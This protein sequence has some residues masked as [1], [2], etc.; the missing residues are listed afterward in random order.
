MTDQRDPHDVDPATAIQREPGTS[1]E[2]EV[3]A[4]VLCR[5]AE[6]V[7]EVL[8]GAKAED[9]KATLRAVAATRSLSDV[10]DDTLRALVRQAREEGRTWAEIGEVLRITR[11][12]AFQRFG[13]ATSGADDQGR[14][15]AGAP[16][17]QSGDEDPASGQERGSRTGEGPQVPQAADRALDLL[18]DFLQGR[19]EQVRSGFD[20]RMLQACPAELLHTALKQTKAEAGERQEIGAPAV[21]V[22]HGYTVVDVPIAFERGDRIGR[23]VLNADGEV[24]GLFVLPPDASAP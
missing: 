6:L 12:A 10:V 14:Q 13:G 20:E 7:A 17:A 1:P 16:P 23:V 15:A 3:M 21:S 2:R 24:S 11:Q 18:G 9:S 5:N 22:R 8:R 19:F 4:L